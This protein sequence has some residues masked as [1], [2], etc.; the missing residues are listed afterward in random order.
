VLAETGEGKVFEE[1]VGHAS[2]FHFEIL[3]RPPESF[4]T[5]KSGWSIAD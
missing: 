1:L 4:C 5:Q 2:V 3:P